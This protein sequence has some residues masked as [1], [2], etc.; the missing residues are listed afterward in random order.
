MKRPDSFS[1]VSDVAN[2]DG[3]L[4]LSFADVVR[5]RGRSMALFTPALLFTHG[6]FDRDP[7]VEFDARFP[8]ASH[9]MRPVY[10]DLTYDNQYFFAGMKI[11]PPPGLTRNVD[12]NRRLYA[13]DES[14]AKECF[15][16]LS[17]IAYSAPTKD[18]FGSSFAYGLDIADPTSKKNDRL[19]V[20]VFGAITSRF[21]VFLE[22]RPTDVP[23]VRQYKTVNGQLPPILRG[24]AIFTSFTGEDP[25]SMRD[26]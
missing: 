7:V 10:V 11:Q 17:G 16:F 15:G 25:I 5:Q 24:Q 12:W 26:N 18:F 1:E 6:G 22:P 19:L 4:R 14:R 23:I 8:A 21:V 3:V 13:I 2:G 9:D 20:T